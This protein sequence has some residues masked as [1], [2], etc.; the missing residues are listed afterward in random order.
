M[1]KN[2]ISY[3]HVHS[4]IMY[5]SPKVEATQAFMEDEQMNKMCIHPMGFYSTL[6]RKEIL[7]RALNRDEP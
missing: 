4:S 2:N 7:T 5:S 3:T 6:K 1:F